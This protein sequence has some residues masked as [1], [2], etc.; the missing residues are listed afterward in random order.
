MHAVSKVSGG[1]RE[2]GPSRLPPPPLGRRTD[3][4]TLLLISDS[5]ETCTSEYSKWL[6][7]VAFSQ[8]WSAPN[9]FFGR[10]STPDPA[11]GAYSERSFR[12]PSWFKGDRTSKWKGRGE[13]KF[14]DPSRATTAAVGPQIARVCSM[15]CQREA[16]SS[17]CAHRRPH[18]GENGVS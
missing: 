11:G 15:P 12:T 5:C 13:G 6:P 8:L 4:V 18:I 7:P 14:L 9:F 3:A 1:F 17:I 10:S 16:V 2:A